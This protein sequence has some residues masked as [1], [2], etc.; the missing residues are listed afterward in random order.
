MCFH[1]SWIL[2][3]MSMKTHSLVWKGEN[4]SVLY[5]LSR[6]NEHLIFH[7]CIVW[8]RRVDRFLKAVVTMDY[9]EKDCYVKEHIPISI[10]LWHDKASVSF[11]I[12]AL[13]KFSEINFNV[14]LKT[15]IKRY[16][17]T[18]LP[19]YCHL[20]FELSGH[21]SFFFFTYKSDMNP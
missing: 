18:W 13:D 6:K 16:L 21:H 4:N 15:I 17:V 3:A 10:C 7:C 9:F 1:K 20:C 11:C 14:N 12:I 19:V 5:M 2:H 8:K